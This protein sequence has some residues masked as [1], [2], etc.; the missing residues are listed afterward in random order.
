MNN[1]NKIT[2]LA[3]LFAMLA[4]CSTV[5]LPSSVTPPSPVVAEALTAPDSAPVMI[6]PLPAPVMTF[7]LSEEMPAIEENTSA[8]PPPPPPLP[9][10]PP[11]VT[12][13]RK[14]AVKIRTVL[15]L[16]SVVDTLVNTAHAATTTQTVTQEFD[17]AGNLSKKVVVET[18]GSI[19]ENL[20]KLIGLFTG[21]LG[22]YLGWQKVRPQ[23][24]QNT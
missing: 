24:A 16:S 3:M 1:V 21:T 10:P 11:K 23:P 13:K 7:S 14:A 12:A 22:L 4:G 20:V 19:I 6:T 15:A 8:A 5:P 9:P 18:R 17:Q 2:P